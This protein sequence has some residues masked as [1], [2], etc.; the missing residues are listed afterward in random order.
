MIKVILDSSNRYLT[1]GLAKDFSLIEEVSYEAWQS[2]SEYMIPEID[3][4]LVKHHVNKDD[5]DQIIVAIGPGSYTGIRIALTIA[6]IMAFACNASLVALSSLRVLSKKDVPSI[7]LINARSSRSYIGVYKDE[8]VIMDDN[9]LSNEEVLSYISS[10][11]E[12]Q[13]CGDTEYLK[14]NGYQSSI[15]KRMLELSEYIS[16][17]NEPIFVK[18]IYLKD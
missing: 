10:H 18:P 16:P 11:P 7:C 15:S 2:Q 13:V 14:I 6:K 3:K 5:I 12:Y 8:E 9:V 1:V 4:L 17:V